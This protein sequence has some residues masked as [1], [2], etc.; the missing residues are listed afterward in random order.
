MKRPSGDTSGWSASLPPWIA[1]RDDSSPNSPST[2]TPVP[3][4]PRRATTPANG[5]SSSRRTPRPSER[6]RPRNPHTLRGLLPHAQRGPH[7][8][9]RDI[10][11]HRGIEAD[12]LDLAERA[13]EPR[14]RAAAEG[15]EVPGGRRERDAGH[16]AM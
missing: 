5:S 2:N 16:Q 7:A 11:E 4:G 3:S 10:A 14:Q 12:A 1:S 15:D 13:E 6:T 8:D 9:R